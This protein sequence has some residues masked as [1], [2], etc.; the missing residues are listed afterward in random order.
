MVQQQLAEPVAEN[1]PKRGVRWHRKTKGI[2]PTTGNLRLHR[3]WIVGDL[4][5]R[6]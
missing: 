1:N 5:S 2:D 6:R 3:D 4:E